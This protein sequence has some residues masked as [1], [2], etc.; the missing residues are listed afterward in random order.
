MKLSE[1]V[2]YPCLE[3]VSLC[4]SIPIQSVSTL[5]FGGRAG[6]DVIRSHVFPQ[7][8]LTTVTSAGAGTAADEA[9]QARAR[10]EM[11]LLLCSVAST[12]L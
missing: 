8:V 11:R 1:T 9:A 10:C 2:I 7:W 5:C 4:G 6:S 3:G 12:T